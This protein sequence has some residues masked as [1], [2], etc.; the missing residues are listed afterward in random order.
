LPVLRNW[1]AVSASL[2][3]AVAVVAA[4]ESRVT[5][6]SGVFTAA[7]AARGQDVYGKACAKC[8]AEDLLGSS[9]AP[10]LVGEAFFARFDRATADDVVDVIRR[11]MPQEAPNSLG[12]PAYVDVVSYLFKANSTPAGSTELPTDRA[13]LREIIVTSKP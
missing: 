12:M 7:Q 8:H 10:A 6:W 2:T 11:T 3:F 13:K 9:N 5:I 1:V 4:Q